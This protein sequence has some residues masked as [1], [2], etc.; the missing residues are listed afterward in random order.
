MKLELVEKLF[1]I[2]LF[3]IVKPM[4]PSMSWQMKR[5]ISFSVYEWR[6]RY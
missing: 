1:S 6:E 3:N 5:R 4:F 2:L